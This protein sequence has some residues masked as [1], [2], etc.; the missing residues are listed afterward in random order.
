VGGGAGRIFD[1]RFPPVSAPRRCKGGR[2]ACTND[3]SQTPWLIGGWRVR[4]LVCFQPGHCWVWGVVKTLAVRAAAPRGIWAKKSR[5][6]KFAYRSLGGSVG[7]GGHPESIRWLIFNMH[8]PAN[9]IVAVTFMA[10]CLAGPFAV[11]HGAILA[12]R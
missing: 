7:L 5:A 9:A 2:I 11:R 1:Y 4:R 10:R 3:F 12:G 6:T 8:I